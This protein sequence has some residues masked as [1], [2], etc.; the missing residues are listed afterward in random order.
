MANF[1]A[2]NENVLKFKS[3]KVYV[4]TRIQSTKKESE[5]LLMKSK[6]L[7]DFNFK[8]NKMS[9][10]INSTQH[11]LNGEK[12]H[13]LSSFSSS[14]E[15]R[16]ISSINQEIKRQ[17]CGDKIVR[18]ELNATDRLFGFSVKGGSDSGS[19]AKIYSINPGK[20]ENFLI[21]FL[22]YFFHLNDSFCPSCCLS[23]SIKFYLLKLEKINHFTLMSYCCLNCNNV[24]LI[25]LNL[26]QMIEV[27]IRF[28]MTI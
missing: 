25:L 5:M 1:Q 3:E 17:T 13:S 14:Y 20:Y 9:E 2:S 21:V 10:T 28:I 16:S 18:L 4:D 12:E 8:K 19:L 23:C 26:K 27:F 6:Y 15:N 22:F 24:V 11:V 7:I